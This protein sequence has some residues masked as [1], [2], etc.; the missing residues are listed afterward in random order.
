MLCVMPNTLMIVLWHNF[1]Q[2]NGPKYE[3][4]ATQ[5]WLLRKSLENKAGMSSIQDLRD[6]S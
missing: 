3:S 4:G 1:L 5:V 6:F 2:S